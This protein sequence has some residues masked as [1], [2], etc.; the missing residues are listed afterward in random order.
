MSPTGEAKVEGPRPHTLITSLFEGPKH[1]MVFFMKII[2]TTE[3]K[4]FIN[5]LDLE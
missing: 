4:Q 3:K 2:A 1:V 5:F